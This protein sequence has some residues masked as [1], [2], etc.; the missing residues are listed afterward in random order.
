MPR[1]HLES[2]AAKFAFLNHGLVSFGV[3]AYVKCHK[4]IK[5]RSSPDAVNDRVEVPRILYVM[6]K[7]RLPDDRIDIFKGY[8]VV[9]SLRVRSILRKAHIW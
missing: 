5:H 6:S 7:C 2:S 1:A 3:R 9:A 4:I 8:Q